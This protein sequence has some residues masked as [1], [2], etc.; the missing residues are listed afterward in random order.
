MIDRRHLLAAGAAAAVLPAARRRIV[1]RLAALANPELPDTVLG[2]AALARDRTGRLVLAEAQGRG[3]TGVGAA[4]RERP[5]TPDTP[6]RVAS[7]SKTVAMAVFMRLAERGVV[8]LDEDVSE[9][10]GWRLRHP[11]HP[12]IAITPRLLASHLSGLR[13]GTSYPVP[14]GHRLE[15]AFTP[16]G[17]H[18]DE[19]S[20]W[21]PAGEP[22]GRWWAYAD[23]NF[24]VLAQVMERATGERFDRLATRLV[25]HPLGLNA[26]YN[27]S[28]V[29]QAKRDRAS[30]CCRLDNGT[31][32]PEV[33][34]VVPRAPEPWVNAAPERTDLR[35]A[36]YRIGDNGFAFSPQGGFRGSVSDLD[37]LAQM[38]RD[39]GGSV[40]S[41]TS[42]AAMGRTV[43]E[44]DIGGRNGG[45]ADGLVQAYALAVQVLRRGPLTPQDEFFGADPAEWRGHYGE[46]Y[47]LVSGMWWNTR[48]RRTLT[49]VINGTPRPADSARGEARTAATPWEQAVFDAAVASW[50]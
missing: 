5:F 43:W 9:R 49:Y 8:S 2:V 24:A 3:V 6:V 23:V 35:A 34:A 17:R 13:N 33:D 42:V 10:L 14:F 38:F 37:K 41:R 39:G 47:G 22:P 18:W 28:G 40:L 25:L 26:G 45:S 12:D 16:G 46:A 29:S 19:G 44:R 27:W 48:D 32:T 21:S 50:R 36:D 20:W 4:R 1:K 30:A 11:A 7:I 15:E 31:W